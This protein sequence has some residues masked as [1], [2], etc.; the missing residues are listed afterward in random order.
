MSCYYLL[1]VFFV[2][3]LIL[4]LSLLS[5]GS[6]AN[7]EEPDDDL[8]F[9]QLTRSV[10]IHNAVADARRAMVNEIRRTT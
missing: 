8:L 5:A 6:L 9:D 4:V 7:P 1:G 2:G 3:L 10:E